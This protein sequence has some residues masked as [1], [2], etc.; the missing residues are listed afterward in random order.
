MQKRLLKSEAAGGKRNVEHVILRPINKSKHTH[1]TLK[2]LPER[3]RLGSET[4]LIVSDTKKKYSDPQ[5]PLVCI[6]QK[7][8]HTLITLQKENR[9]GTY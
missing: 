1:L 9:K 2:H 3:K 7:H 5:R 8:M 6:L 4:A